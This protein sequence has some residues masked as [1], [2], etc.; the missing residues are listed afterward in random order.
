MPWEVDFERARQNLDLVAIATSYYGYEVSRSRSGVRQKVLVHSG[1]GERLIVQAAGSEGIF[2][3]F[4]PHDDRDKGTIIDFILNREGGDWELLKHR[5]I[6]FGL[7]SFPPE[8]I[9]S[10]SP[11]ASQ[12]RVDLEPLSD[13]SFLHKR[14]ISD[15]TLD[16][17]WFKNRIGHYTLKG[18]RNWAF[19]LYQGKTIVGL[20]LRNHEFKGYAAGSSKQS[21]GWFSS[22]SELKG[23]PQAMLITE[24]AL[25][26]LAYHELFPP[27]DE[28]QRLYLSTGGAYSHGQLQLVQMLLDSLRPEQVW[29]G[30]DT[31]AAGQAQNLQFAVRMSHPLHSDQDFEAITE[32]MGK[33]RLR[34]SLKPGLQTPMEHQAFRLL[35]SGFVDEG[36]EVSNIGAEKGYWLIDI[37]YEAPMI[38]KATRLIILLRKSSNWLVVKTPATKDWNEDL[39]TTR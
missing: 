4:N 30:A 24:S 36:A 11:H 25:D 12:P 15:A 26:A 5:L 23:A 18:H 10:S 8:R 39:C 17:P 14:G 33:D 22:V 35:L 19:P 1:T 38:S 27:S 37:P 16:H 9:A 21:G 6:T 7:Q 2:R 28:E 32:R 29:L 3:Y 20:E 13:R 34:I 31:D